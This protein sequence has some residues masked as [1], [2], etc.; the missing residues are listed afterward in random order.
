M[1]KFLAW[2]NSEKSCRL[3]LLFEVLCFYAFHWKNSNVPLLIHLWLMEPS[4]AQTWGIRYSLSLRMMT[5]DDLLPQVRSRQSSWLSSSPS[6]SW[7]PACPAWWWWTSLP[8]TR[9]TQSSA[10][11][12]WSA[13]MVTHSSRFRD[14]SAQHWITCASCQLTYML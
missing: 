1:R 6:S 5:L 10:M 12:K 9:N 8:V 7:S 14:I 13:M 4:P 2:R 3:R 11:I